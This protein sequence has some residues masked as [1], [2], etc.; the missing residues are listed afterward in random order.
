MISAPQREGALVAPKSKVELFAAIRRD[1]WAEGLSVRAL[2][3]KY[4]VHRRMVR[5]ALTPAWP[6]N[7]PEVLQFL[8]G[9]LARDPD[10]LQA[11]LEDF[12]GSRAHGSY[13]T[14]APGL[15]RWRRRA[16]KGLLAGPMQAHRGTKLQPEVRRKHSSTARKALSPDILAAGRLSLNR[17]DI[18]I[19]DAEPKSVCN[20]EISGTMVDTWRNDR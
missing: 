1:S 14:G 6:A 17:D 11:S 20:A 8:S 7:Q 9:W 4:D 3:R 12:T 18:T 13:S 15:R 5:E 19:D 16:G 10:H 2:V